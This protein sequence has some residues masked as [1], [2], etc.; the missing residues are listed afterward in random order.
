MDVKLLLYNFILVL[1]MY[2]CSSCFIPFAKLMNMAILILGIPVSK[3]I[4]YH[5]IFVCFLFIFLAVLTIY[6]RPWAGD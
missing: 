5:G 6:G 4:L 3:K 1:A 2:S